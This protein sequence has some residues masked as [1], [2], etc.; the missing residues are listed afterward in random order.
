M[1]RTVFL[2]RLLPLAIAAGRVCTVPYRA[3][4]YNHFRK[5]SMV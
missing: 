3:N 5:N 2:M 4:D 1:C